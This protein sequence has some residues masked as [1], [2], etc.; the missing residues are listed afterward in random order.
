M[1]VQRTHTLPLQVS[2]QLRV[3]VGRER[4]TDSRAGRQG[5]PGG[6]TVGDGGVFAPDAQELI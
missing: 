6:N 4:R 3:Q 5:L 2:Q 1:A